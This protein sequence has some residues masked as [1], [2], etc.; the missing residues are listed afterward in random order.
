[1]QIRSPFQRGDIIQ[2]LKFCLLTGLLIAWPLLSQPA[3]RAPLVWKAGAAKVDITPA[4][5]VWMAGYSARKTH[6]EGASARLYAKALALDDGSGRKAV[7]LTTDLLG[8]TKRVGDR[9]ADEVRKRYGISRD[10]LLLNSSHTHC[11]PVIDDMLAVAYDLTPQQWRDTDEYT[12]HLSDKLV[13]VI[14][15][16]LKQLKPAALA[17]GH[18]STD[19]GANRRR[20]KGPVDHDV[21]FLRVDGRDGK[22]LAVVFGYACHNTTIGAEHCSFDGDYAGYAQSALERGNPGAVA[23]F[24]MGA[25]ADINP[26]PR[27]TPQLATQHGNTLAASVQSVLASG[28]PVRGKLRTAFGIAELRF[29]D[30]PSREQLLE[31]LRDPNEYVRRHARLLLRTLARNGELDRMYPDPVQVW[32]F[33]N[34]LTLIAMGG[35]VV[36]DYALELKRKYGPENVWIAGYSNDVF[37]YVPSVRVLKEGGYEGGGAMMYYG[38]TGP[39]HESVEAAIYTKIDELMKQVRQ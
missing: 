5:P 2:R 22:P 4:K 34:D 29:A 9:V 31:R 3:E 38:Q 32:A 37:G 18:S 20:P 33:G 12:S 15:T 24:V 7:L 17:V 1:M 10:R 35:E 6:S 13:S 16:A 30:P 14:G 23:L 27:G 8:L 39:F 36:V 28:K 21:P 26:A 11:G 19:F 25:G